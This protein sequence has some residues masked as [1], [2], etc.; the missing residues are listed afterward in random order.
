MGRRCVEPCPG[1]TEWRW[2]GLA[3]LS[4]YPTGLVKMYARPVS[5]P[6]IR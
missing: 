6:I 2:N 5:L 3:Y 4:T 1:W